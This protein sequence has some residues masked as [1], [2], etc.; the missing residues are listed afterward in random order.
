MMTSPQVLSG[1]IFTRQPGLREGTAPRPGGRCSGPSL[2]L[3]PGNAPAVTDNRRPEAG[4]SGLIRT[5]EAGYPAVS[6]PT[7]R[8]MDE[9]K[10]LWQPGRGSSLLAQQYRWINRQRALRWNPRSQ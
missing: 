2:G 1:N 8:N 5:I 9:S 3:V 10:N 7:E 6:R 4:F